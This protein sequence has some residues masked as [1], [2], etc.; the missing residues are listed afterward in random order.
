MVS[1]LILTFSLALSVATFYVLVIRE[2][3]DEV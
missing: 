3:R 1:L 2:R